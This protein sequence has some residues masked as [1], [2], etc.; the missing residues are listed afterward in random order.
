MDIEKLPEN[1][2]P[3][4]ARRSCR[5]YT[6]ASLSEEHLDILRQ[7]LRWAPS[8][9]NRQPWY[10]YQIHNQQIK[11]K[12]VTAAGGQSFLSAA[13][14]VFVVCAIPERSASRYGER[15]RHLYVLQDTA[16]AVQNLMLAATA[17]GYGSCWVGA[18]DEKAVSRILELPDNQR[19][20]AM[21]PIGKTRSQ[22]RAPVRLKLNQ[23]LTILE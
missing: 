17:L 7:S 23:I 5:A 20:V 2:K 22:P 19:P 10:F 16:A 15:G 11:D 14:V 3:I 8:G 13:P 12:L 6:D 9:G 18:F 1:L 21:I 4:F